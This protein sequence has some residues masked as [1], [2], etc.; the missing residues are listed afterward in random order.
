MLNQLS[1]IAVMQKCLKANFASRRMHTHTLILTQVNT[2]PEKPSHI[3]I[4]TSRNTSTEVIYAASH[5][6]TADPIK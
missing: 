3:G 4:L 2:H 6:T 5:V 1:E